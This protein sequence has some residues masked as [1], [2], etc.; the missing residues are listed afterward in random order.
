MKT[1][2]QSFVRLD[3]IWGKIKSSVLTVSFDYILRTREGRSFFVRFQTMPSCATADRPALT[4]A[5]TIFELF[6]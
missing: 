3:F 4:E 2:I 1:I 5:A 6:V